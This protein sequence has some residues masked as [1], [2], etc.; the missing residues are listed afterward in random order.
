V[1]PLGTWTRRPFALNR[2][3]RRDS[4]R[5]GFAFIAALICQWKAK[6]QG[7]TP[8]YAPQGVI[9]VTF[10]ETP[11]EL[12]RMPSSVPGTWRLSLRC[13]KFRR[14]WRHFGHRL[15]PGPDRLRGEARSGPLPFFFWWQCWHRGGQRRPSTWRAGDGRGAKDDIGSRAGIASPGSC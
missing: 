1:R 10:G 8:N 9:F 6:S 7:F 4:D 3:E 13:T 15:A 5:H 14:D 2:R 12:V 11:N